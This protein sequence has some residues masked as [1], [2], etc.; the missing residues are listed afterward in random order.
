MSKIDIDKFVCSLR[1]RFGEDKG[2]AT[3]LDICLRDQWLKVIDTPDGGRLGLIES[4][5]PHIRYGNP[6]DPCDNCTIA[7]P[8]CTLTCEKKEL[9]MIEQ[10]PAK[11]SVE[12]EIG[13]A[14]TMWAVKQARTIAKDENDMGNLWYAEMWLKSLKDRYTWKPSDEQMVALQ[15]AI[16]DLCGKDEHNII[17]G[18]Y[19]DLKKLRDE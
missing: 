13:L 10:K 4:N 2:I 18:L 7:S 1:R 19:Y 8:G 5:N 16:V 15:K 14:D 17:T 3:R 12:D 9:K 11:W 6:K